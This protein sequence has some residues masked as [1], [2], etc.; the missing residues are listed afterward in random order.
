[1]FHLSVF[2]SQPDL[3]MTFSYATMPTNTEVNLSL[4]EKSEFCRYHL[5]KLLIKIPR[6]IRFSDKRLRWTCPLAQLCIGASTFSFY[7]CWSNFV[8]FYEGKRMYCCKKRKTPELFGNFI[9]RIILIS[10]Q[11]KEFEKTLFLFLLLFSLFWHNKWT[12]K[13]WRFGNSTS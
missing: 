8:L 11:N 5:V 10:E 1:M 7:C 9:N 4:L 3:D 2:F 12:Q 6:S 13:S